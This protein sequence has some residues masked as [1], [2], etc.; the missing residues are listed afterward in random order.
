MTSDPFFLPAMPSN[1]PTRRRTIRSKVVG[2]TFDNPDGASRQAIIKRFCDAGMELEIRPEPD[3]PH[4]ENA[5]GV[6][7]RTG[8]H[9]GSRGLQI[10]YI[11]SEL[12]DELGESLEKG[13][14]ISARIL[15]VTGGGRGKN[16]GVNIELRVETARALLPESSLPTTGLSDLFSWLGYVILGI[17]GIFATLARV[18][19]GITKYLLGRFSGLSPSRKIALAGSYVAIAGIGLWTLGYVIGRPSGSFSFLRPSGVVMLIVGL[20]VL[21][22]GMVFSLSEQ[23]KEINE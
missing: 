1:R 6:W 10:G 16:F 20:G 5:L 14:E 8:G 15:E 22:L 7:V 23:S 19:L 12:A 11:R 4:D 2:V 18:T 13:C 17:V 3:N 9:F 21:S